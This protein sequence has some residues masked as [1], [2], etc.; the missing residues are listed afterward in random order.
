[1]KKTIR[2]IRAELF[3]MF[4]KKTFWFMFMIMTLYCCGLF[5]YQAF[6][7][8]LGKIDVASSGSAIFAG[9]NGEPEK[10]KDIFYTMFPVLVALPV[11]FDYYVDTKRE[12]TAIFILG[13]TN[14]GAYLFSKSVTA[15]IQNFILFFIP[16]VV[17]LILSCLAF[18]EKYLTY[19]G[20]PGTAEFYGQ[21]LG[22]RF[23]FQRFY[24]YHPVAY[25]FCFCIAI[26]LFAGV[27]GLFTY[28]LSLWTRNMPAIAL[29]GPYLVFYVIQQNYFLLHKFSLYDVLRPMLRWG[30]HYGRMFIYINLLLLGASIVMIFMRRICRVR[31]S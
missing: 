7:F 21:F 27:L 17:N 11:F 30:K 22:N 8:V 20:T 14:Q 15:F 10:C 9:A 29:V 18:S 4:H 23:P 16:F 19:Y 1:M 25:C 5:F 26:G 24:L 13:K 12:K 3:H 6:G 2:L 28:S 31:V